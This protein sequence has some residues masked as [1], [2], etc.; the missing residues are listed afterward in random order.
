MSTATISSGARIWRKRAASGHITHAQAVQFCHAIWP[1]AKGDYPRG[2]DV[3]IEAWEA[4]EVVDMVLAARPL[5]DAT[6]AQRG[7]VWL[8]ANRNRFGLPQWEMLDIVE[9]RFVG[10]KHHSGGYYGSHG[11]IY[12]AAWADGRR[13]RYAPSAWQAGLNRDRAATALWFETEEA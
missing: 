7:R 11:P 5:V 2:K 10:V 4:Q 12:E 8:H 1:R 9:F 6:A 3:N 13:L